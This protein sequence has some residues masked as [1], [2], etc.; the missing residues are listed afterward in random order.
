VLVYEDDGIGI[1]E[2][3]SLDN[4]PGFGLQLVGMLVEQLMG[5]IVLNRGGGTKFRIEI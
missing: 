1:P 2:S 4:S 3:I 5:T